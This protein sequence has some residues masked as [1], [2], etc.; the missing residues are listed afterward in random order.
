MLPAPIVDRLRTQLGQLP[1]LI[2]LAH[3]ALA[4]GSGR[5]GARVSGATRTAPLPCNPGTLSLIGPTA[6]ETVHDEYGDQDDTPG[7]DLLA[8]WAHTVL[9]D[10]RR[11]N[12]WTAWLRPAGHEWE[13]TVSIA[14]KVIALHLDFAAARPYA[15][16]M[17][18]E[19]GRLHGHLNRATGLPIAPPVR[20]QVCPRCQLLTVTVRPDGM[21]ECSTIDCQ[22]VLSTQE[23]ADRAER[24]LVELAA[25]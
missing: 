9:E 2:T 3:L 19:I 14:V 13:R 17:A 16:D 8:D 22:A 10:R 11:A 23:Y 12:D 24:T 15:R 7:L 4:P 25:A 1:E 21:R 20:R 18:D 5:R 6:V